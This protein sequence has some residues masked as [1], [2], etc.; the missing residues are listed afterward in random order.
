MF[1]HRGTL[2]SLLGFLG[3]YNFR[4][5]DTSAY[6]TIS[7]VRDKKCNDQHILLLLNSTPFLTNTIITCT[8]GICTMIASVTDFYSYLIES[9]V[10]PDN[11]IK[12]D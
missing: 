12:V 5:L 3:V 10:A 1:G 8:T 9:V 6:I 7:R 11:V 2:C 4:K